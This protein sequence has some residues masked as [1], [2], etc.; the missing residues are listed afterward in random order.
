VKRK[1]QSVVLAT[2]LVLAAC[3]RSSSAS[4]NPVKLTVLAAASLTNVFPR[5]GALFTKEH[6]GT[7]FD[8]SFAGTD[9]LSAQIQQGAPGDVFAGASTRYG[10]QLA[11]ANEIGR[12][13]VFCTNRLVLITPASNPARIASLQ[14]LATTPV[15]LVI[16]SETV[17][18][19]TYTR[20]VLANLDSVYGSTY[21][22]TVL[23]TVVSNEDSVTSIVTKIEAGEA[24]AG[25]VYI[26]DALA[27]GSKVTSIALPDDA[28][29]VANYPIAVVKSSKNATVARKFVDFV[30]TAPPQAMLEAAGFGPPP[31]S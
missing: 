26:T 28:Q 17:P 12:Y 14:D 16:G 29:A 18:V 23:G 19:G 5:I 31:A 7:T 9:Q 10:D 20:T 27:A 6:P 3:S 30:L 15:K 8:F 25:F 22:T 11:G 24:D 1:A 13:E 21:S 4:S 2:G